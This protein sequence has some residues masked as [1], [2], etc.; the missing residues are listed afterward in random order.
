MVGCRTCSVTEMMAFKEI[1]D[2]CVQRRCLPQERWAQRR[3]KALMEADGCS[4]L[5]CKR[6]VEYHEWVLLLRHIEYKRNKRT[7]MSSTVATQSHCGVE[8]WRCR[9][10]RKGHVWT[11]LRTRYGKETLP[12]PAIELICA[13]EDSKFKEESWQ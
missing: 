7:D 1:M 2:R 5:A 3:C 9:A 8:L 6:C 10:I 11:L 12:Y 13:F 4:D